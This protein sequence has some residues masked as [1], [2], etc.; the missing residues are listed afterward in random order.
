VQQFDEADALFHLKAA[1]AQAS[2]SEAKD[3]QA[4]MDLLG[5]KD[6]AGAQARLLTFLPPEEI[7]QELFVINCAACHGVEGRGGLGKNLRD[8]KFIQSQ[9]D[10]ELSAFIFAGREGTA[11]D[12]FEGIL[13]PED[14]SYI[15][16]LIRNWQK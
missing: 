6:W 13:T 16:V 8:N 10:D 12:S 3:I 2:A 11:M 9:S 5:Q 14:L 1:L 15:M 4:V 7:G